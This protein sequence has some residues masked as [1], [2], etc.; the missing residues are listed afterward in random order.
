MSPSLSAPRPSHGA[1]DAGE[2]R[3]VALGVQFQRPQPGVDGVVDLP[4]FEEAEPERLI[5]KG[6]ADAKPQGFFISRLGAHPVLKVYTL[7]TAFTGRRPGLELGCHL[8]GQR[9]FLL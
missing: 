5:N 3:E 7:I 6:I 8:Q 4:Q 2:T 9:V 1:L